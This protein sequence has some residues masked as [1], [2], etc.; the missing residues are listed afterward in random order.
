[1][2]SRHLRLALLAATVLVACSCS[3][4]GSQ[5]TGSDEGTGPPNISPSAAPGVAFNYAYDFNL[6]DDR[7]S[8]TQEAHAAACENL[9]LA[10]CRITGMSFNVNQDEDVTAE[11]DLKLDPAIARQ[12][13]KSAQQSVE[14]KDGKLIR[15][16]IGSSDEG[17]VMQQASRQ[18]TDA[19]TQLPQL[20]QELAKT[21]PGTQGRADLLNQIEALQQ[22]AAEQS[23]A[24][25]ASQVALASTPMEFHYYGRGGVPG[26]RG[27]PI[28]A[29]WQTFLTTVVWLVGILLQAAAV[30][31][32]VAIVLA[33]FVALWRTPPVRAF[34]RW[35]RGPQDEEA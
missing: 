24:I 33:L 8:A 25:E 15:L 31:L 18:R 35:F 26:F 27:N 5:P 17:A 20:Q 11:L 28:R 12:F 30:L 10:R 4:Q 3:K 29:A 13:G 23:H 2:L 7:I 19:S 16:A 14:A 22:R 6:G 32:P 1:M 34:R 21:K 9:G